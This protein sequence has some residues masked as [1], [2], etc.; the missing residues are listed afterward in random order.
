MVRGQGMME[1]LGWVGLENCP[2]Q[3]NVSSQKKGATVQDH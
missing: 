1:R 2:E 3:G